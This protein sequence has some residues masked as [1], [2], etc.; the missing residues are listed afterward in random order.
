MSNASPYSVPP[1]PG[2]W[3]AIT[4]AVLVHAALLGLLWFGVRWQNETPNAVEAEVWDMKT[5]QAAPKP[6]PEP[7]V[8]PPAPVL[9]KPVV[10]ARP[11][12]PEVE[13]PAEKPV[14]KPDIA[15][16]QEKKRKAAERKVEED[17][18]KA[19]AAKLAA[20][21]LKQAEE[22]RLRLANEQAEALEKKKR[23][24][25][26][27]RDAQRKN[28]EA[29]VAQK[30]ADEKAA[31][32]KKLADKKRA[33]ELADQ[34]LR[35]KSRAEEMRRLSAATGSGGSGDAPKS[36][37]NNRADPSYISKVAA[38]IKSNTVFNV[39]DDLA[40]NPPVEYIVELLPD[41]S[42]REVRKLKSSGVAGFDEAVQR[43]IGKSAP[44]P[45][46]KSGSVPSSF[47]V[48]YKP[49]D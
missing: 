35:D 40:G 24:A 4:L 9:E 6:E 8:A 32:K 12:K 30:L 39:P 26:I 43:A 18:R 44:Y 20:R 21:E 36:T 47:T 28:E 37:G 19:E 13:K 25:D 5:R 31:E 41:G 2:R 49:K 27:Q 17:T 29:R 33:Q 3:R 42:I 23:D 15:L 46:D 7:E 45:Q 48:S 10:K 14:E 22:K 1:E 38:K 34:Q 16:E 11:P